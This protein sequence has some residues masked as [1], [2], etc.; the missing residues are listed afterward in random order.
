MTHSVHGNLNVPTNQPRDRQPSADALAAL[1]PFLAAPSATSPVWLAGGR[2]AFL[3]DRSGMAQIWVTDPIST[4]EFDPD[5]GIGVAQLTAFSDR[6][7]ALKATPSGTGIIFGMDAGGNEHQQVW[8]LSLPGGDPKQAAAPVPLTDQPD[9]IHNFGAVSADGDRFAL[10]SN[11]RDQRFFDVHMLPLGDGGAE[12]RTLVEADALLYPV[13]YSP[14]GSQL[15]IRRNNSNLDQD[16]LLLADVGNEPRPLTAHDG[17]AT[18]LDVAFAPDGQSLLVVTNRDREFS[19]LIRLSLDGQWLDVLAEPEWDVELVRASP[20]SGWIAYSVNEDGISRL[21]LRDGSGIEQLI[22]DL[23]AGTIESAAWSPDG[24]WLAVTLTS[25]VATGAVWLV[26]ADGTARPA[27]PTVYGDLDPAALVYPEIIRY[28]SFDGRQIPAFWFVPEGEGPFPVVVDVHGGPESQRRAD[29]QYLP[30]FLVQQGFAVLA[31]NVRGS[32]GYGRTYCH[33]DDR[34]LRYDSVADLGAAHDWLR[35]REEV[36]PEFISIH[37][38][39]YGGFMVLAAL[40]T[41]PERWTTG[42]DVVGIANF[43]SFFAKTGAWRRAVRAAEYGDPDTQA[44]LLRE[45]SPIHRVEAI[46]APLFVMHGRNDPRVPLA[47]T[48]QI[49]Q[50]I[51]DRD[52]VVE[53]I[54]FDDE[55]HGPVRRPNR[56]RGYGLVAD[57]LDRYGRPS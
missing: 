44:D 28:P 4:G 39:S 45:L 30:Q 11:R 19:A 17:E 56:L 6:I 7:T 35:T 2:I 48:E 36:D 25:P 51:Q 41:Q 33:L 8:Y 55:G 22:D 15:L 20:A 46:R 54:V 53:L 31:P 1:S 3:S 14:D 50:A 37:G 27:V 32:T 52:G 18:I 9:V 24:E 16:L 21:R 38:R 40:T 49:V 26:S 13:A 43:V 57:F 12:A 42:I 10:S 34:D 23:P 5:D 29:W 47:E